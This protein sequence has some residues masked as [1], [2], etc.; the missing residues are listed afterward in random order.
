MCFLSYSNCFPSLW[1]HPFSIHSLM[2]DIF[3]FSYSNISQ[4]PKVISWIW[5]N[6]ISKLFFFVSS[7]IFNNWFLSKYFKKNLKPLCIYL[8]HSWIGIMC[9]YLLDFCN[10]YPCNSQLH[11]YPQKYY[12]SLVFLY[13]IF[14]KIFIFQ[15]VSWTIRS[16]WSWRTSSISPRFGWY[17][18]RIIF[19][20][21][22]GSKTRLICLDLY[23]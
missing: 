19:G 13:L 18:F 10:T 14:T 4:T 9:T 15:M 22:I 11:F 17:K 8:L 5:F 2:I 7:N 12:L 6:V 16:Y 20:S 23:R 3:L 1:M 21:R